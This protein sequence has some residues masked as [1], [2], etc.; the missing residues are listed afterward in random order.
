MKKCII[1]GLP[2]AGKSTYIGAFWAI[3]KDGDTGHKLVCSKYPED[4]VYLDSLK[5]SWKKQKEVNRSNQLE[6]N[7]IIFELSS[8]S[9]TEAITLC[10]PDFKGEKFQS[11]IQN[12]IASEIDKWFK[13]SDTVLFFL[14]YQE[15]DTL[16]DETSLPNPE[17]KQD[18]ARVLTTNE[19]S[20]WTKNIMLLKY[21]LNTYKI[22]RFAICIS[23]WDKVDTD[24][25]PTVE[26]WLKATSPF[27]LNFLKDNIKN[28]KLFGVSAQGIDY[29][30]YPN[31]ESVESIQQKTEE[32]RRAYVYE[33]SINY[34][35]TEP[36][37]Y[38]ISK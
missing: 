38:L 7:E 15:R 11:I 22:E 8:Q 33:S 5:S 20:E 31:G 10:I 36:L 21:I 25:Y 37:Y 6:E 1:V 19:M 26:S 32:N 4:S 28:F 16:Q 2:E 27:F 13:E 14:K 18:Q 23:A 29:N 3:E 9:S 30:N 35:I 24:T 34:D 12:N 17:N